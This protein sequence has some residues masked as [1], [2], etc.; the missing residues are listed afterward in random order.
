MAVTP[1]TWQ[2]TRNTSANVVTIATGATNGSQIS[3]IWLTN[4]NSTTARTITLLCGGTG[5]DTTKIISIFTIQP[6]DSLLIQMPND[7]IVLKT[8][9]TLRGYQ[10]TSTDINVFACGLEL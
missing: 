10:D 1:Q 6:L 8:G 3:S 7:P 4:T 2:T 5:T 9:V